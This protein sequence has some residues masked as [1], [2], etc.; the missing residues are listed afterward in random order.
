MND[1]NCIFCKIVKRELPGDIVYEN[2]KVLAFKD[3]NPKAPV[4]I[5]IVPKQHIESVNSE[6]SENI[7]KDLILGAKDIIKRDAIG[8]YKLVFNVGKEAGQTVPHLHVHLLAGNKI[9]L[10]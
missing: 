5:L 3:I 9:E 10:P 7:I 1:A 6:N 2:E 8:G 4:H